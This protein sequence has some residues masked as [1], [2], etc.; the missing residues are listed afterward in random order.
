MVPPL[1]IS[2]SCAVALQ[3]IQQPLLGQQLSGASTTDHTQLRHGMLSCPDC[4]RRSA[5][6]KNINAI[7]LSDGNN[8]PKRSLHEATLSEFKEAYGKVMSCDE[9]K[10]MFSNHRQGSAMA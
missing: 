10:D 1:L 3:A 7:L 6:T 8:G 2:M 4:V 5:F 9:V